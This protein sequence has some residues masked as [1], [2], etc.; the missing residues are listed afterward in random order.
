[1]SKIC[2]VAKNLRGA[3]LEVVSHINAIIDEYSAQ[4]FDLTVRQVFYQLVARALIENSQ[5]EYKR[6]VSIITD[7]RMAGLIDWDSIVDRTRY[8]RSNSHWKNPAHIIHSAA[9]SFALDKWSD[10]PY[11]IEVWIEKD[12]LVGVL[13][14]ACKPLDVPFFSCRGNVSA[15]EMH[16]AHLRLSDHASGGQTPMILHLGDHD[17]NGIDMS[18]DIQDRLATFGA[19]VEFE[20]IALN[21][22]QVERYRPPPNFAKETDSRFK[23]YEALYGKE[24]WELDALDP[25]TLTTLIQDKIRSVRDADLWMAKELE[26]ATGREKLALAAKRWG[27]VE[28]FLA[29]ANGR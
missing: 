23:S 12:A 13:E 8:L 27:D 4:G 16:E 25:V 11:R 29:K 2:Y 22:A 28:A 1:M 6:I 24:C 14:A 15:S 5:K 20:R 21:L 10:Q 3:T 9:Q 26:E 19:E 18:R 17:P 7:A